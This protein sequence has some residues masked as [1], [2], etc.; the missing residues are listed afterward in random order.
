MSETQGG[1]NVAIVALIVI[2]VLV[3][4]AA[5]FYFGGA[6]K[7]A[8]S[9]GSNN[10]VIERTVEKATPDVDVNIKKDDDPGLSM[11]HESDDGKKT[12]I[13]ANP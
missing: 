6:G 9:G 10:T 11:S 5:F 3:A 4:G 13:E 8:G 7:G 12:T 2:A 1:N